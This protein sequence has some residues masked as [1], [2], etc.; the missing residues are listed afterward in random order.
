MKLK[1]S[2]LSQEAFAP[3]GSYFVM[4]E[5]DKDKNGDLSYYPD[6]TAALLG[7]GSLTGFSVCG[8]NKRP[9]RADIIEIHEHTEEAEF[10]MGDCILLAGARSGYKPDTASFKAFF[11]PRN[12]LVRFKRFVWHYAP[13]PLSDERVMVL[14]VL[15]PYTH[16]N[17]S[18]VVHL[19]EAI[20]IDVPAD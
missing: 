1:V 13:Y 11:V 7:S 16:L 2:E 5:T 17:D 8:I 18:V 6:V 3:F 20:E 10:I 12:T 9:M 15:P 14:T 4:D 19:D